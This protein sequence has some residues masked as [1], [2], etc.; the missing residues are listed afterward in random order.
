MKKLFFFW[1]EIKTSFWFIP[2]LL[3]LS[4]VIA[5]WVMIFIDH[6]IDIEIEGIFS[7]MF[8]SSADSARSVLSIISGAMIGVAGT[9]FSI[10]LVAL[11][12]ASSNFGSRLI[13]NFMYEKIN[14]IVLGAYISSFIYCLIVLNV[15]KETDTTVFIP[16][17][18]VLFA[19]ILTIINIFLLVIFIHHIAVS[20]QS[21][22]VVS[23]IAESLSHNV[24]VLFPE[25]MGED[26]EV[27]K[28]PT[29]PTE[30]YNFT[31]NVKSNKSGYLQYIDDNKIFDFAN[32]NNLIVKLDCRPGDYL[33][34]GVNI[35]RVFSKDE[36]EDSSLNIFKLAFITGKS[37]TP[38]QDAE[39]AIHQMV[40]I[41]ARALSP[42][43]NDPYTAIACIDNLTT[44]M[45]YLSKVKFPSPYRYN[46]NKELRLI[47]SVLDFEGMLNAAFNQIRQFAKDSPSVVIRLMESL[48]V[49][50]YYTDKDEYKMAVKMHAEMILRLAEKTFIEKNDLIDLK[51]R[52]EFIY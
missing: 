1:S 20:I 13:R 32:K 35:A 43:V 36:L 11:T 46:D 33:V 5:A 51:Q 15:I 24:K 31:Y 41:A 45:C 30:Y 18:S 21:D 48:K 4:A 50:Y 14:Q 17:L 37:R 42:G 6:Q 10:T 25:E 29:L 16:S 44:T 47:A 7:F 34:Q 39:F 40:E 52:S 38:Q 26:F 49:V 8:T 23:D 22:K 2:S 19:I 12:L 27:E 28:E 9:V 3:I